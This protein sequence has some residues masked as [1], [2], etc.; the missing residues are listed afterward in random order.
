MKTPVALFIFKRTSTLPQII[1]KIGEAKPEKLYLLADGPRNEAEKAMTDECRRVA[2]SL[3]TWDCEVVKRYSEQNLGV[4]RNIGLGAKYVF[5][6]EE[7]AVFIEDDN[8][9]DSSFVPY[10]EEMLDR[11]EK[12]GDVL[13]ICG[14][15]YLG[16]SETG[17][18]YMFTRHMLPCGWASWRDKYV[19]YY[20]GELSALSDKEKVK[21]YKSTYNSA[22]FSSPALYR[23]MMH[24]IIK[25]KYLID[26][27][28]CKAS[29]DYQMDWSVRSNKMYGI[30][31]CVNL[32]KNIGVD[33]VS[34][35][36][37][38][39]IS[40]TM[41][42]RFCEIETYALHFPLVHPEKISVNPAYEKAIGKI[43]LCPLSERL[44]RSTGTFIK[45]ILG[46]EEGES[47]TSAFRKK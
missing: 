45:R 6:S 4:Y 34:E 25:T 14:T 44:K 20:D 31:P 41:T 8:L 18:S 37:G 15:N 30:S 33:S 39:D 43:I 11:Y 35:H 19:R 24:N 46:M 7:R 28:I 38:T 13:W 1:G 21:T 16:H 17:Y 40:K 42:G 23:Q 26:N 22:E 47:L 2:E 5:E 36:G 3:I 10:C 32:I 29:W 27:G 9:P 12:S